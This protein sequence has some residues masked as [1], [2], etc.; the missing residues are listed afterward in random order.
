[1]I[2]FTPAWLRGDPLAHSFLPRERPVD[3][4]RRVH[5]AVLDA[6]DATTDAQR[7]SRERL[8]TGTCVVTGQQAGLFGG[9]LYTLY[10]AAA[11]IVDARALGAAPVFWLQNEDHDIAEIATTHVLA[12]D[13]LR[14]VAIA[15][16]HDGRSV[17]AHR[18]GPSVDDALAE[19][20]AILRGL[21]HADAA[22]T[23]LRD[24]Y[25]PER[26][27]DVAFRALLEALFAEHG[28]LVVDP[29]HPALARAAEVVHH[30]AIEESGPIG[31]ILAH[32][33]EALRAAG[34][35]VQVQIRPDLP[36]SFVHP[37]GPDAPRR[38]TADIPAGATFSTSAL[39]RPI[40]QDT[41]LPTSAIVAGPGEIAYFAQ[42]PPLYA[43]F[44]LRMPAV[45]PRASF[46]VVDEGADRLLEQLGLTVPA[47]AE[48]RERLLARL[49][50]PG[51]HADPDHVEAR[52]MGGIQAALDDLGPLRSSLG[53]TPSQVLDAAAR[54]V[55]RYRRAVA[56][57]DAVTVGR[58]DRLIARL[59][60]D[61]APQERVHGWPWVLARYGPDRFVSAVLD[62]VVPFDGTTRELRP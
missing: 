34:F 55:E 57:A 20:D 51:D 58:L 35:P 39:L 29:R 56:E 6:V 15:H 40:L 27:P 11:A 48:A 9:P 1:M 21:T 47:L 42:L 2:P 5:P 41:W 25:R 13:G 22:R 10:K 54:L 50:R 59:R 16:T 24:T 23:L 19:V 60:P 7:R 44:G 26:A 28:L 12:G 45:V 53:K 33:A 46:V 3:P 62:A 61:G 52:L 32:R 4:G 8:A 36:L 17:G 43:H 14:A 31:E 49:A 30:R 18:L 37:E 38:R